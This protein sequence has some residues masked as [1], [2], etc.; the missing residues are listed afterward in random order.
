MT[1]DLQ[2]E[3]H[4]N[5]QH[6][7]DGKVGALRGIGGV[8]SGIF[9]TKHYDYKTGKMVSDNNGLY[10][11]LSLE[12]LAGITEADRKIFK[13]EIW[14]PIRNTFTGIG[15]MFVGMGTIVAHPKLGMGLLAGGIAGSRALKPKI[16]PTAYNGTYSFARFATPCPTF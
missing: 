14:N 8:A 5:I 10:N 6:K 9:G 4:F 16:D 3:N 2:I 1:S 7:Q 15:A 11:Q 12:N 13:Q